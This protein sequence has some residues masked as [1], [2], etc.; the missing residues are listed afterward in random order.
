MEEIGIGVIGGTALAVMFLYGLAEL[1]WLTVFSRRDGQP[2]VSFR[3]DYSQVV[4][5]LGVVMAITAL[6]PLLTTIGLAL[7]GSKFAPLELGRQWYIWPI[8]FLIYEFWYWLQH[9]VAHKVR[10]LWCVHS[11]HHAPDTIN[12]VVGYNHHMLE[13]PYMAF[14]LGFM[15]ALC[16]VPLE[17]IVII[18]TFDA[19]WGSMLHASP[20]VI[21]KRYGPLEYFM[22]TPSYHRAHHSQNPRYMDTNYNPITFFWDWVMGTLQPLK[23]EEPVVYGITRDVDVESWRDVQFGEVKLLW[24][25]V[26]SAPGLKNKLCYLVMP[27]G[28]SHTGDH[29]M[30]TTMKRAQAI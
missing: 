10:L 9:F 13:A 16:G 20:R 22:Q 14:F 3:H 8:A 15:P 1:L 6:L 7:I 25:D 17:M 23:D 12:M 26:K 18:N 5:N 11:P 28:W 19:V 30:A 4:K 27:P 29:K 21:S 24:G 2:Q